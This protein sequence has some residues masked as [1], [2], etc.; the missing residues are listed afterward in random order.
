MIKLSVIV[1]VYN[2]ADTLP[3][4]L[5]SIA[6]QDCRDVEVI[7]IDDGSTDDS[8]KLCQSYADTY[9]NVSVYTQAHAGQSAARNLG[10]QHATGI[11]LFFADADDALLPNA[12]SCMIEKMNGTQLLVF[13]YEQNGTPHMYSSGELSAAEAKTAYF[14]ADKD[15]RV[16]GS[17]WNKCFLR[18]VIETNQIAFPPLSRN[19]EEVFLMEYL[20][21]IEQIR[22][23]EQ[24]L[25]SFCPI[26]MQ[27]AF[28]RMPEDYAQQVVAFKNT[29]L[30]FAEKW[31]VLTEQSK[32][33][34]AKEFYGKMMLALKLCL[35]P[36][37]RDKKQFNLIADL[38]L[39]EIPA[40]QAVE[41][42]R[43]F[44]ILQKKWYLLAYLLLR[45][46]VK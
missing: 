26:T 37:H 7:L 46:Q 21:H 3:R 8:L 30:E 6:K 43:M 19:E 1:P 32:N 34:I 29:C 25:Y 28:V 45:R 14:C 38:L 35:N 10:M 22:F 27:R 9:N 12:F 11:Y 5:E 24:V 15:R 40:A 4:C 2:A 17:I 44:R 16:K 33:A 20:D 42:M 41:S 13:G 39:F 31:N 36:K 23:E 18:N